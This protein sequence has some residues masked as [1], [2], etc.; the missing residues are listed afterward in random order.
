MILGSAAYMSTE[1]ASLTPGGGEK[2]SPVDFAKI[3]KKRARNEVAEREGFG[4][5]GHPLES[6]TYRF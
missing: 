4:L 3:A 5:S 1:Q 6:V 2:S